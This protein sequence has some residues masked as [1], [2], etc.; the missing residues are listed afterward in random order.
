MAAPPLANVSTLSAAYP[1]RGFS[2]YVRVHMDLLRND[3][4]GCEKPALG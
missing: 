3:P 2:G 1:Q 4:Q